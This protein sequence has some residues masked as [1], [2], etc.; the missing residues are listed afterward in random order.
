MAMA[1]KT[2][3]DLQRENDDLRK[4]IVEL[5]AIVKEQSL[6]NTDQTGSATAL[7][8]IEVRDQ[9]MVEQI[10]YR[11]TGNQERAE[12]RGDDGRDYE[13]I[14]AP[15]PAVAGI[16]DQAIEIVLDIT[17]RK[18]VEQQRDAAHRQL[19]ANELQL[20][21]ANQRLE[22]S[23]RQLKAA[24]EKLKE[25]E[26][27]FRS[28]TEQMPGLIC[29]FLPDGRITYVNK[30]YGDY[31]G[32]LPEELIGKDLEALI[33]EQDRAAVM[34]N[35]RALDPM[36]PVQTHEHRVIAGDGADRWQRWTHRGIFD[37][38]GR[39]KAYQSIGEDITALKQAEEAEKSQINFLNT[40][41]DQSP[42]AM[43][44]SDPNGTVVRTN[45][46]LRHALNLTDEQ[47][48]GRYNVLEDQNLNDHGVMDLV[49]GVFSDQKPARFIIPWK[50][51]KAGDV[52]F[53]K[54]KDLWIDVSMF[55]VLDS[56]GNHANT[57]CQWIDISERKAAEE[58]LRRSDVIVAGSTDML[59]LLDASYTYIHANQHYA[60]AFGMKREQLVGK[61]VAQVLG[62]EFFTRVIRPHA[63]RCMAG[64][65]VR[66][67]EWFDLPATGHKY[68]QI[69]YNPYVSA[70]GEV[71]GFV[72]NKRDITDEKLA[73]DALRQHQEDLE[74]AVEERT[75]A[76]RLSEQRLIEE[77]AAT[78][79]IVKQLLSE[80]ANEPETERQVLDACLAA[81]RSRF[82]MIG[83]V[84]EHGEFETTT[85][86]SETLKDCAFPEAMAGNLTSGMN[87]R[88]IWAWPMIH[89]EPLLCND[90]VSHPDRVEPP[91]DHTQIDCFLGVPVMDG[92]T[93]TGMV[94]VVNKEG[95]YTKTDQE[96]LARLVAIMTVSR[97]YRQ[98]LTS[99]RL[100]T[101]ELDRMVRRRTA[102]LEATN[103]E[104][105]AFAYSISHDLRAPLRAIDG[106]SKAFMEDYGD[107]VSGVGKDQLHR[108]R[109]GAQRMG[110]LID[111]L[112]QLSRLTR[113]D[114]RS[115]DVDLSEI[116]RAIVAQLR[117]SESARAVDVSIA[118]GLVATGDPTLLESALQNL[119]S[120]AWKFTS[121]KEDARIEVGELLVDGERTVFVR[122]NGA[123]FDMAYADK[124]FGVFQRLH[125]AT[126]FPGTG[127]GLA[128]VHRVIRRHGGRVWADGAVGQGATFYFT[129][130]TPDP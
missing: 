106:F 50:P 92:E 75:T 24:D 38:E 97:R 35:I 10:N 100:T 91:D 53:D 96:T 107:R 68:M 19:Q 59:A 31:F 114:A 112:L 16:A 65:G 126:E 119:L 49:R 57:V 127:V 117:T 98:A 125:D 118:P 51:S 23:N 33:P 62:E 95:G 20:R 87:T 73:K 9:T 48:L 101:A 66:Y 52:D 79:D 5:A 69:T 55:P 39:P 93:V 64:E 18:K 109:V 123:G 111:A 44:I 27:F 45:R 30:A 21:D 82:G 105:E 15:M 42:F 72:V 67:E 1:R 37:E 61:T 12:I 47:I 83:A 80:E 22:A 32:R 103:R 84:N 17:A 99:A 81:T 29:R 13:I 104:L 76:L 11:C 116:A 14:S 88:G 85:H 115:V 108:V 2:M 4:R 70:N 113:V 58:R 77:T 94:A 25:S 3:A 86:N 8:A 121:E 102:E 36:S 28:V 26:Q 46:S 7:R 128:T 129:L 6:E 40:V 122:D 130:P 34:A 41:M 71:V 54:G 74:R 110:A 120:N 63:D 89:G 43:W 56:G 124:L 78:A 60:G 90:L